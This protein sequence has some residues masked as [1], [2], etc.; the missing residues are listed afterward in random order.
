MSE[1][2]KHILITR[3]DNIGD[4]VFTLPLIGLLRK[5]YP[6]ATISLL[7]NS[8]TKPLASICPDIDRVWDWNELQ[9][10]S[11]AEIVNKL[12]SAQITTVLHLSACNHFAKLVKR[13]GI[14]FRVT[15]FHNTNN[16]IYCNR[17]ML[18]PRNR[19]ELHESELNTY[20]L[21]LFSICPNVSL[22]E[23]ATY[24]H[25]EPRTTLPAPIE[26]LLTDAYFN[27][28]LHPGSNGHGSEWP[29]DY[30]KQLIAELSKNTE[31]KIR[32]FLTGGPQEQ[33]R[34]KSL[35]ESSPQAINLMGTMT[36]DEFITFLSRVD[37]IIASGTGPLHVGAALG[38]KTLGLFP[39]KQGISLTRWAPLGKQAQA[40][41]CDHTK[42]CSTCPG[43]TN[44]FCMA[45]IPVKQVLDV[46]QG[47]C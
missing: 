5:Y 16:L 30:F 11:N 3:L 29:A 38:I 34:F 19:L 43:S 46:I 7:I 45:K 37:G 42:P 6:S 22:S 17:W 31:K 41:V 27:L 47:W 2:T 15:P 21:K 32:I 39:P 36:L 20:L 14:P 8:Y 4:V 35:I 40:M 9:R 44:C 13:A 33:E 10:T 12:R 24:I 1:K 28:I 18:A 26:S 25:L 23:M